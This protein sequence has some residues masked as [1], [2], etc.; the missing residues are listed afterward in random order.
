MHNV[1][2]MH[3][4]LLKDKHRADIKRT[5]SSR[6]IWLE[7][8]KVAKFVTLFR[9]SSTIIHR[10]RKKLNGHTKLEISCLNLS[11]LHNLMEI[12]MLFE[13]D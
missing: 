5:F 9:N 11:L 10:L 7:A 2:N 4:L 1:T 12:S 13:K 3:K 8:R 6:F